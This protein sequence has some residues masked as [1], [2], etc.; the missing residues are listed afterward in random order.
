MTVVR[1]DV[2]ICCINFFITDLEICE[3]TLQDVAKYCLL[4]YVQLAPAETK[5]KL[6][7]Y[8]MENIFSFSLQIHVLLD[9]VFILTSMLKFH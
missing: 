8:I 1:Y 3:P 9:L 7:T 6:N 5:R 2:R 4:I